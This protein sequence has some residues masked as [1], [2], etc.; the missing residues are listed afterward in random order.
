MLNQTRLFSDDPHARPMSE[1]DIET[2]RLSLMIVV[3][4]FAIQLI[5]GAI[6]LL[7]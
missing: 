6:A 7:H 1:D 4:V 3:V 5:F 2:A